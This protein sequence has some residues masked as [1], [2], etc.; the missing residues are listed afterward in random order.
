MKAAPL[1]IRVQG[2]PR[3][4]IRLALKTGAPP[5]VHREHGEGGPVAGG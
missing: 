2:D 1:N 5:S 3:W 4:G